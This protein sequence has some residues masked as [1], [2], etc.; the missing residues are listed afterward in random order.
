MRSTI[1]RAT[2]LLLVAVFALAAFS[3]CTIEKGYAGAPVGMRPCNEG[4]TGL[5]MY[6]PSNWNVDN[7]G[8]IP[9]AYFSHTENSM[10][11]LVTVPKNNWQGDNSEKTIPEYWQ[12]QKVKFG[13]MKEFTIIKPSEEATDELYFTDI[14]FGDRQL[15]QYRY[16]FKLSQGQRDLKYMFAQAFVQNPNTGDL[17]IITYSALDSYFESHLDDLDDVYAN[18]KLVTEPEPMEGAVPK[19]EYVQ[20]EGTPEGYSA[21]TG[22][23]VDYILFVPSTWTPLLNTGITAASSADDPSVSCNV[24]AFNLEN[25][26]TDLDAYYS[27]LETTVTDTF[28]TISY[29]NAENKYTDA[30]IAIKGTEAKLNARKYVYSVTFNGVTYTYEQYIMIFQGYVYQL[31]FCCKSDAYEANKTIFDGIAENFRFKI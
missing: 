3:S 4:E 26:S 16:S 30:S 9:T 28:G 23:H 31:T 8:S 7:S 21:L 18:L 19:P 12:E 24:T 27:A 17:Y 14:I 25:N 15:F 11:T 10:I 29:P 1:K 5:I 20:T 6:V 2:A 13:S 22:E